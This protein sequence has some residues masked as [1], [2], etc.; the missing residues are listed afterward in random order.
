MD[1][2]STSS[3]LIFMLIILSAKSLR[4]Y[5]VDTNNIFLKVTFESKW[6]QMSTQFLRTKTGTLISSNLKI[7][8]KVLKLH[9]S[10]EGGG[11][12]WKNRQKD[13]RGWIESTEIAI[14]CSQPIFDKRANEVQW[15]KVAFSSY[16]YNWIFTWKGMNLDIGLMLCRIIN[17]KCTI[18]LNRKIS[19]SQKIMYDKV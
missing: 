9:K 15:T 8:S 12:W 10:R 2:M 7:Y 4:C 16:G 6:S 1:Y 18:I 5:F 19:N 3:I 17:S 13:Q 14:K 11:K